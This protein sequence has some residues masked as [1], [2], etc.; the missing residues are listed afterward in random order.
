M[1]LPSSLIWPVAVGQPHHHARQ[2]GLAAAGLADE[3]ERG[4]ARNGERHVIDRDHGADGGDGR[5][6]QPIGLGEVPDL[7]ERGFALRRGFWPRRPGL[8]VDDTAD[9]ARGFALNGGQPAALLAE[10][11]HRIEQRLG[12]VALGTGKQLLLVRLLHQPAIVHDD[13]AVSDLVHDTEI[14]GDE[15]DGRADLV[16][17]ALQDFQHLALHGNVEGRR[18]LVGDDEL[19]PAGDRHGDHDA[20]ALAAAQLVWIGAHDTLRIADVLV[21]EQLDCSLV[22]SC[23]GNVLVQQDGFHDLLTAGEDR[24]QRRHRVLEDHRDAAAAQLAQGRLGHLQQVGA[25]E[26]NLAARDP[27]IGWQKVEN[28]QRHQC[29]AATAFAHETEDFTLLD[30]EGH[31]VHGRLQSF[32]GLKGDLDVVDLQ[33]GASADL[34]ERRPAGRRST[35][36]LT[37]SPGRDSLPHSYRTPPSHRASLCDKVL[38]LEPEA[39]MN[40]QLLSRY[41]H[42]W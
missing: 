13:D 12:V 6:L 29:L 18:R 41:S 37:C 26:Q 30:V 7:E 5:I 14:V 38:N 8:G 16:V 28:T 1:S 33:H 35:S 31:T 10:G 25:V 9:G 4:V 23:A 17:Q 32:A 27:C 21:F 39:G 22:G 42:N 34:A 15:Q 11:R 3:A 36:V 2:G 40:F 19:G 20:L 24:I